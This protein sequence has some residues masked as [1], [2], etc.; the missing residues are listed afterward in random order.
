MKRSVNW[1]E[2]RDIHGALVQFQQVLRGA[3]VL[4]KNGQHDGEGLPEPSG[5]TRSKSMMEASL[6]FTWAKYLILSLKVE[7]LAGVSNVATDWLSWQQFSKMEW[8]LNRAVFREL[9]N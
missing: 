5:G 3:H 8:Q 7:H 2:F 9:Q 6:L 1:L 4:S